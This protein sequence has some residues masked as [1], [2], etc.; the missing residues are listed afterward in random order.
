MSFDFK[1]EKKDERR[2]I[3]DKEGFL[4]AEGFWYKSTEPIG[5]YSVRFDAAFGE[6]YLESC[7][8]KDNSKNFWAK[9]KT[10][11]DDRILRVRILNL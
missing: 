3:I 2:F 7:L 5:S 11:K 10:R 1:E 9:I 4:R 8:N 6:E